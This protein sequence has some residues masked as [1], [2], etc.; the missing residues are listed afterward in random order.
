MQLS[1]IVP[2]DAGLGDTFVR[3]RYTSDTEIGPTGPASNGEV[4]D[5]MITI[6]APVTDGDG[7]DDGGDD[8]DTGTPTSDEGDNAGLPSD[9]RLGQNYPN[10]FNPTTVI[11]FDLAKSGMVQLSVFDVTGRKV[12]TLVNTSMSAGRHMVTFNA[13]GIP[14][15]VYIV[16]LEAGGQL[17]TSKLTLIK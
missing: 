17:M 7:D 2:A 10:P 6:T 9:F 11:P 8:G 15:G 16:R 13:A 5:Y 12:S 3:F 1:V 4:E 14:S